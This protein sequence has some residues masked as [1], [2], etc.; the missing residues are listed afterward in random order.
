MNNGFF[1]LLCFLLLTA[2]IVGTLGDAG[3]QKSTKGG[4][5]ENND[6]LSALSKRKSQTPA[7]VKGKHIHVST[8]LSKKND[9]FVNLESVLFDREKLK[10]YVLD[11]LRT[12]AFANGTAAA[13]DGY[14]LRHRAKSD[15]RHHGH[16]DKFQWQVSNKNRGKYKY[17]GHRSGFESQGGDSLNVDDSFSKRKLL[18]NQG[19]KKQ[20]GGPEHRDNLETKIQDQ[21]KLKH[22][23]YVGHAS[24]SSLNKRNFVSKEKSRQQQRYI[25]EHFGKYF[26]VKKYALPF[27]FSVR[28]LD[29]RGASVRHHHL[30]SDH[31]SAET[32]EKQRG[33]KKGRKHLDEGGQ[34]SSKINT[35]VEKPH[36][37]THQEGKPENRSAGKVLSLDTLPHSFHHGE[38]NHQGDSRDKKRFKAHHRDRVHQSSG[39]DHRPDRLGHLDGISSVSKPGVDSQSFKHRQSYKGTETGLNERRSKK[40]DFVAVLPP[41]SFKLEGFDVEPVTTKLH[42]KKKKFPKG[43]KRPPAKKTRSPKKS[44]EREHKGKRKS[45]VTSESR[46]IEHD[47]KADRGQKLDKED[48]RKTSDQKK[49]YKNGHRKSGEGTFHKHSRKDKHG[50]RKGIVTSVDGKRKISRQPEAE[51][52]SSDNQTSHKKG[53][54]RKAESTL[55]KQPRKDK[56][57]DRKN[58]VTSKSH[59]HGL[60]ADGKQKKSRQTETERKRTEKEKIPRD[61]YRRKSEVTLH[62]RQGERKN[63]VVSKSHSHGLKAD[64]VRKTSGQ[65]EGERKRIDKEKISR[66][67]HRKKDEVTS[68]KHY[69]KDKQGERTKTILTSKSHRSNHDAKKNRVT[70]T[71]QRQ[72]EG[73]PKSAIT[74]KSSKTGHTKKSNTALQK[75]FNHRKAKRKS[76]ATS[77]SSKHHRHTKG[78]GSHHLGSK[79]STSNREGRFTNHKREKA[80]RH[81]DSK[82]LRFSPSWDSLDKRKIPSWYDDAKFGIFVHWGVYSVP[83]FGSEWFWYKWKGK[84]LQMY[85]N[86]TTKNFPPG[87]SYSEF[88]PMFKAEFFDAKQWADLVARSGARYDV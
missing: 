57:G 84:K 9:N 28:E 7:T 67:G 63:M 81:Q 27:Y 42:V 13:A 55:H 68:H 69:R 73:S 66:D 40:R 33:F 23:R 32:K 75:S 19:L 64:G 36:K 72:E 22:R 61:G 25:S 24:H 38:S 56:Q 65:S 83:S 46:E 1:T 21:A 37:T 78:E 29:G 53:L 50:G 82:E 39:Y 5:R 45:S 18:Q 51:R 79:K 26:P 34:I 88:A 59:R 77:T 30:S 54:T 14:S 70:K 74:G 8:A 11:Y 35:A 16:R 3:T 15:R 86:Y 2:Q 20:V 44:N 85:L 10:N 62:K 49:K 87:F 41:Q 60:K 43:Q 52:R 48:N 12:H 4:L 17:S 6:E 58:I 47:L 80:S 71:S 76:S 31:Q